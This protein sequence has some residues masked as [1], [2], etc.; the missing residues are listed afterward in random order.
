MKKYKK[1]RQTTSVYSRAKHIHQHT[2]FF[3]FGQQTSIKNNVKAYPITSL[4]PSSTHIKTIKTQQSH[5]IMPHQLYKALLEKIDT[6]PF[7]CYS[8]Y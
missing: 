1:F 5:K 7:A 3:F 8:F 2:Q 4:S 6:Q